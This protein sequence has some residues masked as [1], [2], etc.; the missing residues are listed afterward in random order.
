MERDFYKIKILGSKGEVVGFITLNNSCGYFIPRIGLRAGMQLQGDPNTSDNPVASD[1]NVLPFLEVKPIF[2]YLGYSQ[3]E[4]AEMLDISLGTL[5]RLEKNENEALLGKLQS[6]MMWDIDEVIAKGVN[7]FGSK[8]N[9]KNWLNTPN[10]ALGGKEPKEL[11]KDPYK[12][13]T[14]RNAIEGMSLGNFV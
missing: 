5:F 12:V 13:E 3:K 14:V 9:F 11:L 7:F 10:H 1:K 6:K 8:E 4:V 2:H